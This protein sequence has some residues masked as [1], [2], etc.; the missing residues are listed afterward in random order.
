MATMIPPTPAA[1]TPR[2]ERQVRNIL[3][4]A[5]V[6]PNWTFIH[7]SNHYNPTRNLLR[8][9]DFVALIPD[10]GMICIEVKG[11]AFYVRNGQ[12]F[13]THDHSMVESPTRQAE[14]AMYALQHELQREFSPQ[15]GPG[16]IPTECAVIFTDAQ[17]PDN[18]RRP[19]ATIIDQTDITNQKLELMLVGLSLRLRPAAGHKKLIPPTT[20]QV[21]DKIRH[22]L[23]PDFNMH[24]AN[25]DPSTILVP[26]IAN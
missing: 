25:T 12:W 1:D 9:I 6:L 17:W 21:V 22:Y 19:R 8:E 11:G 16:A 3:A 26:A 4:R 18:V 24:E 13:R 5:D 2:S 20:N 23:T 7:S 14:Q 10:Y 15:S